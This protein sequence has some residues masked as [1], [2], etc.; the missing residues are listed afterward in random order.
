MS[1]HLPQQ[2]LLDWMRPDTDYR[3][4]VAL[5]S[6]YSA[7]AGVLASLLLSLAGFEDDPSDAGLRATKVKFA[8]SVLQLKGRVAIAMQAGR[9]FCS[10]K[11]GKPI[12]L[13]DRFI[14]DIRW[15]ERQ[16][17]GRSWHPKC[18]IVRYL[19]K[20]GSS[21]KWR[22]WLGS[23][24]LTRDTSW[25]LGLSLE[26]YEDQAQVREGTQLPAI[27]KVAFRLAEET[28]ESERWKEP[29]R[30]LKNVHWQ[31]PRGLVL[32][33]IELMLPDDAA[34][35]F[36]PSP[37]GVRRLIAVAPFMDPQTTRR[38]GRWGD[39]AERLLV[40]TGLEMDRIAKGS[41]NFFKMRGFT[42]VRAFAVVADEGEQDV[43]EA[44]DGT[45]GD[46][47][48][49]CG[50]HA[51]FLWAEHAK[52]TTIWL[53][54]P[55][56][57]ER[58][59]KRNAEIYARIDLDA[60]SKAAAEI[61]DGVKAF[62]AMAPAFSVSSVEGPSDVAD[63]ME[64]ARTEVAASLMKARQVLSKDWT[65]VKIEAPNA[66]HPANGK[67]ALK[68]GPVADDQDKLIEWPRGSRRIEL[69][70]QHPHAASH[71]V[72]IALECRGRPPAIWLQAIPIEGLE[73]DKRDNVFLCEYLSDDQLFAWI[74]QTL[75]DNSEGAEG[76]P[77][78]EE[79]SHGPVNW[80]TR[81]HKNLAPTLE[82]LLRA[83]LKNRA[84]FSE[85][86]EIMAIADARGGKAGGA[87]AFVSFKESLN[88]IEHSLIGKQQP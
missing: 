14:K 64:F 12:A 74:Y 82:D 59:W 6:T 68:I 81:K 43:V 35:D 66:P 21:G 4:D 17:V 46:L 37:S 54:S 83:W 39:S 67:F 75:T 34:R 45:S 56:L 3:T 32:E 84:A 10:R 78:D 88:L 50:L 73:Q 77:W 60:R 40:S 8:K 13:L 65:S 61:R 33:D 38:L 28:G 51:K 22:L 16:K 19:E 70:P 27:A 11:S 2:S 80:R 53:G 86:R 85:V 52:G 79:K 26:G 23:R 29:L 49:D 25:D 7:S 1:E 69:H 58:A 30:R 47:E 31:V 5:V 18:A 36:L 87:A 44:G 15:D 76:G 57:T 41:D 20:D 63:Q 48:A 55:N 62:V 9:L 71:L 24:N 42:D 72:R